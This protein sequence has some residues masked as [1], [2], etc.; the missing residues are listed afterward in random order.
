MGVMNQKQCDTN[1]R[2]TWVEMTDKYVNIDG[3]E[4]LMTTLS[5]RYRIKPELQQKIHL[6]TKAKNNYFS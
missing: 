5:S 4:P 2:E 6:E 3:D 1:N